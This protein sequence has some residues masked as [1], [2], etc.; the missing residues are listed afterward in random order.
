MRVGTGVRMCSRV[1]RPRKSRV[2]HVNFPLWEI[3]RGAAALSTQRPGL[4]EARVT[5]RHSR[6]GRRA[7]GG[8][9][10]REHVLSVLKHHVS[11]M[12]E[13]GSINTF[14]FAHER[15]EHSGQLVNSIHGS[16]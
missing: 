13:C 12:F 1:P 15:L 2:A 16:L 7:R 6:V 4:A 10:H 11:G 9:K 14:V 5:L 8:V 3:V